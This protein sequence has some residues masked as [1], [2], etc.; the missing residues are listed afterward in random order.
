MPLH[1]ALR[2]TEG[3]DGR[4]GPRSPPAT[5]KLAGLPTGSGQG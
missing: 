2:H 4:E 1:G 3:A 5:S